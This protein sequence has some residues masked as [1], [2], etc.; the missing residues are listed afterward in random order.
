MAAI[1]VT[2]RHVVYENPT[3]QNRSRHGYFPGPIRLPSGDLL[4]LFVLG[5]AFEAADL[6]TVVSRSRDQGRTWEL[7]GPLHQKDPEHIYDADSMKPNLLQD[8]TILATGYRFHRTD[9]DQLLV[10]TETDGVRGGDNLVSHSTDE[11]RTWTTPEVMQRSRPEL[12]ES[13]GPTIQLRSGSILGCG[14][15]FPMWDGSDPSDKK[16]VIFRS[17]D[18]G[19]TW[20]DETRLFVGLPD[21][22]A[23]SEPRLCEM[24]DGRVVALAWT[25]N[26]N[27][28]VNLPNHVAVSHDGGVSWSDPSDTG[29]KAQASNLI[30]WRD[31]LLLSIHS[32]REGEEIG[33]FVRVVD[34]SNDEWKVAEAVNVWDNAPSMQVANYATMGTN[35]RFGQ[36]SLLR[37]DGD[38]VLATHWAVEDGQ[39][40]ISAHRLQVRL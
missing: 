14:S 2:D 31:D 6:T 21:G 23:P 19:M 30:H 38:E 26:H 12:I 8:G 4:A 33:I 15:L 32:H 39:G 16:G 20:N 5:E 29:V 17:E 34:F 11:G 25:A 36:P 40:R 35:L 28:G 22:C 37:L 18:G 1:E 27:A 3:P 10:N 13:S 7:E 24:S 9:P